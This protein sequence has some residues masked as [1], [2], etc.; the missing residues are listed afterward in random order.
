MTDPAG[1][2]RAQRL[3]KT[4]SVHTVC[5]I[6]LMTAAGAGTMTIRSGTGK[7]KPTIWRWQE[8]YMRDGTDGLFRDAPRGVV[9][10]VDHGWL[11]PL[12]PGAELDGAP[13]G[14]A[15]ELVP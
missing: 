8:R 15:W 7:G 9:I 10:L 2:G 11:T 14:E 13:R 4:P 6:V 3:R 12:A 1:E 5:R